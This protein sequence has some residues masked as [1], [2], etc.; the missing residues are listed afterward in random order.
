MPE[1][2]DKQVV[3]LVRGVL[4]LVTQGA[5]AG[6]GLYDQIQAGGAG[7]EDL[8]RAV[9]AVSRAVDAGL[10]LYEVARSLA[11]E[12]SAEEQANLARLKELAKEARQRADAMKSG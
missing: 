8:K 9:D 3:E 7:S 5:S 12:A 6:L 4:A 11:G 1:Q 2:K 10:D